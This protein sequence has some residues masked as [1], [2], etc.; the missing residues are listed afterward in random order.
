MS[1]QKVRLGSN[2]SEG[3]F[4]VNTV[5][6]RSNEPS[7]DRG[8]TRERNTGNNVDWYYRDRIYMY[9]LHNCNVIL[10][11]QHVPGSRE[12]RGRFQSERLKVFKILSGISGL[13]MSKHSLNPSE[14]GDNYRTTERVERFDLHGIILQP[15][16]PRWIQNASPRSYIATVFFYEKCFFL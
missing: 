13:S 11:T 5:S 12:V 3:C 8:A 10:I 2:A 16:L 15:K 9:V 1:Y 7:R 6:S 14:L 4:L